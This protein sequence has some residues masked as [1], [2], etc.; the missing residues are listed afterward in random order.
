MRLPA[1]IYMDG[2]GYV[3]LYLAY[4]LGIFNNLLTYP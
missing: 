2:V 1:Y 3:K 4:P